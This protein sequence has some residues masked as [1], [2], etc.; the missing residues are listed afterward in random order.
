MIVTLQTQRV[1]TL[2]HVRRVAEANETVD[3]AIADRASAYEFIRRTLVQF[4]YAALGKADIGAVKAYLAKMTGLSRAQLTRLMARHRWTG[5]IRDRRSAGRAR[6]FARRYT[7][8]EIR[9]LA[10]VD[11]ALGQRCGPATFERLDAVA[12]VQSEVDA[13]LAVNAAR[14]ELFRTITG[15]TT[16]HSAKGSA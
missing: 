1:Q 6:P 7:A 9:L 16:P 5:R 3:F 11:A 10:E 8:A 12:Y 13:A 15:T 14:D 2:E 4:V